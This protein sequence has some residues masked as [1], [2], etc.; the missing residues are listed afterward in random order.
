MNLN[1]N[2]LIITILLLT[3]L[4]TVSFML[5]KEKDINE[6]LVRDFSENLEMIAS[7]LKEL[8]V[9]DLIF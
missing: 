1:K 3:N 5:N 2:R 6:Y 9:Y 8:E 4:F 7:N